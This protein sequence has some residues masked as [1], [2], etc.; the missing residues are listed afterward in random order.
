M[1]ERLDCDNLLAMPEIGFVLRKKDFKQLTL[2]ELN[3]VCVLEC[4]KEVCKN[5]IKRLSMLSKNEK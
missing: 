1:Y 2:Q 3:D 4:P 5:R